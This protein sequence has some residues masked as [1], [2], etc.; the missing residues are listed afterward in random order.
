V[1]GLRYALVVVALMVS[2]AGP[3][4]AHQVNTSYA[5]LVLGDGTAEFMLAIDEGDLL[6]LF[7]EDLDRN[8]DGVLWVDEILA[9]VTRSQSW[10][11]ERVV[12]RADDTRLLLES[13]HPRVESD[14]DGNLFLKV[15][16]GVTLP[17][18][19]T[20]IQV[21]LTALLQPPLLSAHRNLLKLSAPGRPEALAV[22]SAEHPVH[23]WR[24]R[25]EPVSLWSQAGR[26]VWLGMEHIWI[27]YDH[28]LFLL[29]LI[30]VGSSLGALVRIVSAFT[31]AHSLTLVMATLE[32]VVLPSRLVESGI[33]LSIIYV[34]AE[35][36][37][38]RDTR[39][40]WILTFC[41]GFV[42]GFGFANVLKD[43]N[44]PSEGLI[45]TLLAFNVGVEIG[46]VTIVTILF[47]VILWNSRRSF[48]HRAVQVVSAI[49]LLFGVGWLVERLF[50]LS[51]MPL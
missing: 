11:A 14:A 49:I 19:P 22:L 16:Y 3:I 26:F 44:L 6:L 46:Q 17:E 15:A 50:D 39:H 42:H 48:H 4:E 28:I 43:L 23:E 35:N 2:W 51:Y 21:D 47:P 20:R 34:A 18:D 30:V 40:R 27:G 36:F 31:V 24:L 9:G 38:R 32:W 1:K 5:T 12:L 13:A 41:F 45:A 8:G 25:E 29:A 7:G 10:L 37:W 33:A